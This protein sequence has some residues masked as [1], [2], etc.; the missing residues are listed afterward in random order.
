MKKTTVLT[1]TLLLALIAR[2]TPVTVPWSCSFETPADCSGWVLNHGPKGEFCNDRWYFGSAT[3]YDGSRSLYISTDS[4]A[5]YKYGAKPNIVVAYSN[6]TFAVG[7]SYNLSFDWK[8]MPRAN[9]GGLHVYWEAESRLSGANDIMSDTA[10]YIVPGKL[11]PKTTLTYA[12]DWQNASLTIGAGTNV[13]MR[14]VF[15]WYNNNTDTTQG[16]PYAIAIDNIQ[17]SST[18]ARQPTDFVVDAR[19]DT[20]NVSWSGYSEAYQLQY[21]KKTTSFWSNISINRST[22]LN[23]QITNI[24]EGIYDFRVRGVSN[25]DTTAWV[26]ESSVIVFC[27]NNHCINYVDLYDPSMQCF[28]G[29]PSQPSS[30]VPS[31]PIDFGEDNTNSR[32]TVC[33]TPKLDPRTKYR[34]RTVPTGEF[35]SIRLGNLQ[36]AGTADR[37]ELDY[38]VDSAT[39]ILIMKYALVM[40]DPNHET[41]PEQPSF[42]LEILDQN[43][44]LIDPECSK[45]VFYADLNAEGWHTNRWNE[46]GDVAWKDWT[47]F[48][49][50]LS[51]YAGQNIKIRV[52]DQGC[53]YDVHFGYAYFTL[54]CTSAII[55]GVSCGSDSI[56]TIEAPI[57]FNYKWTNSVESAYLSTDRVIEV[58]TEDETTY[59][60]RVSSL[61]NDSCYFDLSTVVKQRIPKADFTYEIVKE[62]CS[63]KLR[64]KNTSH[65]LTKDNGLIVPTNEPCQFINWDFGKGNVTSQDIVEYIVPKEGGVVNLTLSAFISDGACSDDSVFS[66]NIPE[67]YDYY[68]V[69]DTTLCF[70]EFIMFNKKPHSIP[71][72]YFDSLKTS[73]GCDSVVELRLNVRDYIPEV[74]IYDTICFGDKVIYANK[75]YSTTGKH[76]I[77]NQSIYGCDSIQYLNLV[78]LDSV[79]FTYTKHDIIGAPKSGEIII[80]TAPDDY[81]YSVNGAMNGELTGL[82]G[83]SYNII[84][85]NNAGCPSDEVEIIINQDC[86]KA[87]MGFVPNVCADDDSIT[88]SV[89]VIEGIPHKYSINFGAK[90][91]TAGFVDVDTLKL[92]ETVTFPLPVICKP[93]IY[94]ASILVHD[95]V[96]EDIVLPFEFTVLYSDTIM[97]QKWNDVIAILS[98]KYNGGYEFSAF[99]WF[100]NGAPL[101]DEVGPYLY[102][103]GSNFYLNDEYAVQLTRADDNVILMSCSMTPEIRS[104]IYDH[105]TKTLSAISQKIPIKNPSGSAVARWYDVQGRFYG[106]HKI[107]EFDAEITAPNTPGIY[108]LEITNDENRTVHKM[109]IK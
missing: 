41:L 105:P 7:G 81:T 72:T 83:G 88:I 40:Q 34:L 93:D 30:F 13:P 62:D 104:D 28:T 64:F 67:L 91:L 23:H 36:R 80:D 51:A 15:V 46:Y 98:A 90:A 109:Y 58:P 42:T 60:C 102:L 76:T 54:G 69:V 66:I 65:V 106:E 25:T 85:Y 16:E 44:N 14:L 57:G 26:S 47:T 3:A 92:T 97:A 31:N 24:G 99:R 9:A 50:D 21:R 33:W 10:T 82:E 29:I 84:V 11:R 35:A 39:S 79:V 52:S 75:E 20:A 6:Y 101:V 43:G 22:N 37:I 108:L 63:T 87:V 107:T 55:S 5:D 71:G 12:R 103:N 8:A 89:N 100:R 95:M 74:N 61:E 2:S 86:L 68:K 17:F 18:M 78:V 53:I 56:M 32:H 70:G 77:W 45:V 73:Y 96:C 4:A 19:C 59:Y 48:G 38:Y 94:D 1:I 27:P 49:L